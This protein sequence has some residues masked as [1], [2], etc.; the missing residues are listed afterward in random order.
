MLENW[1]CVLQKVLYVIENGVNGWELVYS[2]VDLVCAS[3]VWVSGFR[4]C[5][6]MKDVKCKQMKKRLSM[7]W[8]CGNYMLIIVMFYPMKKLTQW[9]GFHCWVNGCFNSSVYSLYKESAQRLIKWSYSKTNG[10][11]EIQWENLVF[12]LLFWIIKIFACL[13]TSLL[14]TKTPIWWTEN[15]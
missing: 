7:D 4:N 14:T 9:V 12:I 10:N 1:V 6:I 13:A 3:G 15:V 8:S 5:L 2:F 11:W